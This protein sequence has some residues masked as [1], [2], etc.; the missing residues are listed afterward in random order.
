MSHTAEDLLHS[1]AVA[2]GR[3]LDLVV[4]NV[5]RL[6]ADLADDLPWLDS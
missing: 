4:V 6:A 5:E 2:F 3:H 1:P